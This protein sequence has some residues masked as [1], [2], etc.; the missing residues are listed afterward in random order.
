MIRTSSVSANRLNRAFTSAG[1]SLFVPEVKTRDLF[2]DVQRC[3]LFV[4]WE[5][6]NIQIRL[7][8]QHINGAYAQL[9]A[10]AI[11][12]RISTALSQAR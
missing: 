12:P 3:P 2:C 7:D 9:I 10:A 8:G 6:R 4:A 1:R 5:G 11:A